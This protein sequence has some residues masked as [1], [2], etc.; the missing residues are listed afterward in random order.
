M[1]ENIDHFMNQVLNETLMSKN[2]LI[3]EKIISIL[4]VF[5]CIINSD[6]VKTLKWN[7]NTTELIATFFCVNCQL[8]YLEDDRSRKEFLKSNLC[9]DDT[10]INFTRVA[11]E[12]SSNRLILKHALSHLTGSSK[13]LKIVTLSLLPSLSNH[14][15]QFLL[16]KFT[17]IWTE[18]AHDTDE[19]VRKRVTEVIGSILK[20]TQVRIKFS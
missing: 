20:Y 18:L 11:M 16:K 19:E 1:F 6:Y 10:A 17:A 14:V 13:V 4:P 12:D 8:N 5:L 7:C 9:V 2:Y 15:E 3:Q